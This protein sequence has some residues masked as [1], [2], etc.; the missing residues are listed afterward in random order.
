MAEKVT[1]EVTEDELWLIKMAL[2]GHKYDLGRQI[3]EQMEKELEATCKEEKERAQRIKKSLE[4]EKALT[5]NLRE[6]LKN[7]EK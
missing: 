3:R 2:N 7:R 5:Q 4:E 1:L 6:R